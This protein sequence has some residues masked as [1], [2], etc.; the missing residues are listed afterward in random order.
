MK[1]ITFTNDQRTLL[2]ELLTNRLKNHNEFDIDSDSVNWK[3]IK[4]SNDSYFQPFVS[5]LD[6]VSKYEIASYTT[7]E[8]T[9]CI[10][11]INEHYDNFYK[12][13]NLP[14][15]LDW[16]TI[17]NEQRN[18][19]EKLDNCE[20]I[21]EK[22]GYYNKNDGLKKYR[23]SFRYSDILLAMEKT[24]KSTKIF[25]SKVGQNDFYKIA[26]VHDNKEYVQFRIKNQ[27]SW[28]DFQFHSFNGKSPDEYGKERF[29]LVTTK[30]EAKELLAGCERQHYP[31]GVL[32]VM[33]KLL[34]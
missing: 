16:L 23:L 3:A 32:D 19:L 33:D 26:F 7:K 13:K 12:E 17:S 10:S 30:C 1:Q 5:A 4:K 22:C 34:N 6:K 11:C 24:K 2:Q 28:K 20:D 18:V 21:L 15:T 8:K 27:I 9:A 31:D 29:T 14:T 25:L